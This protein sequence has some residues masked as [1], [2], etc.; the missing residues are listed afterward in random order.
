MFCPACNSE[1]IVKNGHIHNGKQNHICKDCRRQFVENSTQKRITDYQKALVAKL[2]LE[3]ISL[4]GICRVMGVTMIWLLDFF[5]E[6]TNEIPEDM[7]IITPNKG[8]LIIELDEMWSFV[9]SK[10][11]KQ[12]I[13]LAI[14]R[15]TRQIV[16]F[17][18]GGRGKKDAKKLWKSLPRAYRQRAICYS[19]FWK[20][21]ESVVPESR[22]HAVGKESGQ[23]NHVE[24]TNC[25]LRQRISRLVRESLAFSKKMDNHIRAIRY[26]IWHFNLSLL[27]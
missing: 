22:H 26:F 2:L 11:N 3:R 8:R 25:T 16:G 20:S 23:T 1:K 27:V 7:G 4:R 10:E 19:D 24:R 17:H 6:I 14:D 13:W 18:I 21:Y 5:R 9:G 12:W 15:D